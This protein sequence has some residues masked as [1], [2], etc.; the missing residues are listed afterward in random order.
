MQ[1]ILIGK[2]VQDHEKDI[3]SYFSSLNGRRSNPFAITVLLL[4][5]F[6]QRLEQEYSLMEH[7]GPMQEARTG[8]GSLLWTEQCT[9]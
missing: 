2:Q 3:V 1:L 7:Q 5:R 9:H 4:S 8:I 6:T